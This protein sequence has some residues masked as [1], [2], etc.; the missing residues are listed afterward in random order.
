MPVASTDRGKKV[1]LFG[2][3]EFRQTAVDN[4]AI[5]VARYFQFRA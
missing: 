3:A 1:L 2:A 5:S 4:A